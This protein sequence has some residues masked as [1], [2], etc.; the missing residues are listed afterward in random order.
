[1]IFSVD[2]APRHK[3]SERENRQSRSLP[4]PPPTFVDGGLNRVRRPGCPR[5]ANPGDVAN[6]E[7]WLTRLLAICHHQREIP[8]EHSQVL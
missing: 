7:Y 1:L 4:S 8:Q 5:T 3:A 6:E 2:P